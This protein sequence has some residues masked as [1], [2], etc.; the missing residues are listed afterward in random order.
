MSDRCRVTMHEPAHYEVW[1][2]G[3]L[4]P[5]WVSQTSVDTIRRI[6]E[7][8]GGP[9]TMFTATFRDQAELH[10]LLDRIY[11]LNLPLISIRSTG[12]D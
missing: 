11:N 7:A 9:I 10:G 8:E 12:R 1:I 2:Q 3:H 4:D 5:S 6:P